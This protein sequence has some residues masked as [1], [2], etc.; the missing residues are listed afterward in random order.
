MYLE[1]GKSYSKLWQNIR[2]NY[3]SGLQAQN[4]E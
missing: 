3:R 2:T 1:L 4:T